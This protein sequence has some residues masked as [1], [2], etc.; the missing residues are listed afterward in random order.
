VSKRPPYLEIIATA[1]VMAFLTLIVIGAVDTRPDTL[2]QVSM[3]S[4]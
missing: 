2:G 3:R 4:D 1:L